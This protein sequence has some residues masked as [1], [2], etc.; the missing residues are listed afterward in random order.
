MGRAHEELAASVEGEE[1][2][3]AFNAEYLTDVLG[4]MNSDA[5]VWQFTGP[6][7]KSLL[8][9]ADDPEYLYVV[10]PMQL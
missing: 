5:V 1:I 4:V 7:D 10:M 2:E 6:L 8:K 9:G 3:I